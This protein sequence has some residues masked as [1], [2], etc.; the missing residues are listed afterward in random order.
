[1]NAAGINGY[2]WRQTLGLLREMRER[3]GGGVGMRATRDTAVYNA[4]IAACK[5][6]GGSRHALSLL[7]DM[8]SL[9]VRRDV[10]SYN[11]SVRALRQRLGRRRRPRRRHR[12]ED[13]ADTS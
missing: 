8:R 6:G 9:G 2:R 13:A 11:E 5:N 10:T 3:E 4:A 12:E 7:E 1:M